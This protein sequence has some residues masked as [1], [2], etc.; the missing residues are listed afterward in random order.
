MHI[1]NVVSYLRVLTVSKPAV[2]LQ[3]VQQTRY[4][5][6]QCLLKCCF[7]FGTL[8]SVDISGQC[9]VVV[10]CYK[11]HLGCA[12]KVKLQKAVCYPLLRNLES[13]A[14]I[15]EESFRFLYN[16]WFIHT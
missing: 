11:I 12:T 3:T 9:N 2:V 4:R 7:V 15:F 1:R 13:V 5:V 8:Q 6:T 16:F 14:Q 10:K